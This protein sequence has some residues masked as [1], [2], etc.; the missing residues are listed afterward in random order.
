[1]DQSSGKPYGTR[2]LES[3]LER[4][5]RFQIG[6][7]KRD[8]SDEEESET[9]IAALYVGSQVLGQLVPTDDHRARLREAYAKHTQQRQ[10]HQ[11]RIASD[12]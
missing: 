10:R 3:A 8:S 4:Y 9:Q 6:Y 11:H 2:A 1:M 5:D 7:W 12:K